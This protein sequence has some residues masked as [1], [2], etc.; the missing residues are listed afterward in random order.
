MKSESLPKLSELAMSVKKGQQYTHYK[1]LSYIVLSIARHSETLE[2]FVVYQ[3]LYEKK[4]IWIRSLE[5]FLEEI[6]VNGKKVKRF[7]LTTLNNNYHNDKISL[8]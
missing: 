4:N 5:M 6:V 3:A 1:G 2:E 7:Q 8:L